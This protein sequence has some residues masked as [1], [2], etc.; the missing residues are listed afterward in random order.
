MNLTDFYLVCFLVG[1]VLSV[2]TFVLGNLNLHIHLPFHMHLP[3]M[4][5]APHV[6]LP[7]GGHA[8]AVNADLPFI[9][10]GTITAFLAWFGGVGYLLSR[11]SN[12]MAFLALLLSFVAGVGGAT[13]VFLLV[14]KLLMKH[15]RSL[16]PMDYDM[17]GVLGR[18]TSTI[19]EDGVGEIVFSQE[20][21]RRGSGARSDTGREIP[22]NVEV[23]VTRYERGIAY[24]RPWD[25]LNS[26]HEDASAANLGQ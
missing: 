19:R 12:M 16:D 26:S 7:H 4:G 1:V 13:I 20:G 11:H 2:L 24:V 10:F 5:H 23:V 22:K 8:S 9:N 18:V 21:T 25:E 14:G 17:I 15:D 3:G 6:H